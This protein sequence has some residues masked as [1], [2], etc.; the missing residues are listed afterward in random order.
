MRRRYLT[1][2]TAVFMAASLAFAGS[3]LAQEVPSLPQVPAQKRPPD[4]V[5]GREIAEKL[6]TNC[7]VVVPGGVV[8]SNPASSFPVIAARPGQTPEKIAG[9]IVVP[10]PQMPNIA[11]TIAEIRDVVAYISS[12][13]PKQ[14]GT[15]AP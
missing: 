12:L 2:T 8:T 9:S 11:L 7:H 5:R 14:T 10:H 15:P 1:R 4:P 6:C 3:C 13:G